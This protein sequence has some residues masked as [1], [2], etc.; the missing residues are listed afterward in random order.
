[1][2]RVSIACPESDAASYKR[3]VYPSYPRPTLLR[4]A[5]PCGPLSVLS[6]ELV[7]Y[8][9]GPPLFYCAIDGVNNDDVA[10]PLFAGRFGLSALLDAAGKLVDFK[11]KFIN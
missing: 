4:P 10:H 9:Y 3:A 1:M 5:L 2:R 7:F 8:C 11:H 6:M